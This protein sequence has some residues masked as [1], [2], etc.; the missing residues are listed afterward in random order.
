MVVLS[1]GLVIQNA[2]GAYARAT[3][4]DREELIGRHVFDA[5]PDNPDDPEGDGDGGLLGIVHHVEDGTDVRLDL[6]RVRRAY[7]RSDAPGAQVAESQH[8]FARY[9]AAADEA[10]SH[11]ERLEGEVTQL[12]R[13]LAWRAVI[14]QAIG[15]VQAERRCAP[16]DAFQVLVALSQKTDT[17]LR[18]V[19]AAL[20]RLAASGDGNPIV[21]GPF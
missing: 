16:D 20:V 2:D 3:L 12:R 4:R 13:A 11:L 21:P 14:D 17:K 10:R 6:E 5:L 15:I 8:R 7:A 1:T 18:E 9:L 19:A